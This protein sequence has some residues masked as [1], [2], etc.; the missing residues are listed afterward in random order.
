MENSRN[1][2]IWESYT[3]KYFFLA[4]DIAPSKQLES[5][6]SAATPSPK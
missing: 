5:N 1:R 2:I 6:N 3:Y 4:N